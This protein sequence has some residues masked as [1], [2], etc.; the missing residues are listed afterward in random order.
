MADQDKQEQKTQPDRE[1]DPTPKGADFFI[2]ELAH[3]EQENVRRYMA[4]ST[5]LA[6]LERK[7]KT[8]SDDP[9]N[10]LGS[11]I[12][13]MV[14]L[15]VLPVVIDLLVRKWAPSSSLPLSE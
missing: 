14:V 2:S 10:M 4:L 12:L 11:V 13:V 1:A 7:G 9:M 3:M 5:R 6:S 15:Q 8:S